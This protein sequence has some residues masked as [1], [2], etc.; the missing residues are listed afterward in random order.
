[1]EKF[2]IR[3]LKFMKVKE[4]NDNYYYLGMYNSDVSRVYIPTL[5]DSFAYSEVT[6]ST[7]LTSEYVESVPGFSKKVKYELDDFGNMESWGLA[8]LTAAEIKKIE[9]FCNRPAQAPISTSNVDP[10]FFKKRRR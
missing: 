4:R 10:R 5:K 7:D 2:L 9:N 3:D 1:M 8:V 6:F